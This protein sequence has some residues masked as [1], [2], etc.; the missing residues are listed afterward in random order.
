MSGLTYVA[1]FQNQ[2]LTNAAQDLLEG[3]TSADTPITIHR[4]EASFGTINQANT[5][6]Q[7]L[8]RSTAGSGG[9][10]VTP[11][12]SQRRNTLA[13]DTVFN[14]QVTTPGTAGVVINGWQWNVV[15]PFDALLGKPDL[16]IEIPAA[17]RFAFF[18][19]AAVGTLATSC[20]ITFTER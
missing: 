11:A 10:A 5:Y 6:F 12:V 19:A 15:A 3:V 14:R 2:T 20:S 18:L 4:I 9:S 8:I 16:E 7:L 17:T 1:S 13:A